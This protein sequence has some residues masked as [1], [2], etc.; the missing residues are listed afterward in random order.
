[1]NTEASL[2]RIKHVKALRSYVLT[3]TW[4]DGRRDNVDLTGLIHRSRHFQCFLDDAAAFKRVRPL[5]FGGGIEWE[6]GLDYGADTLWMLA[7]EQRP[8]SGEDLR[9]FEEEQGLSKAETAALLNISPRT[10]VTY[11]GAR[12][13]PV[14]VAIVVR[15]MRDE[16]VRLVAHY[17][18]AGKQRSPGRPRKHA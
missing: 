15:A 9:R 2:P 13:L 10:L 14:P 5:P 4:K 6:N 16:P 8:M 17:R 7:D 1:M 3:V 18:P 11:H 12:E